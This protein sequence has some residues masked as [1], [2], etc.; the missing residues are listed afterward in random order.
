MHGGDDQVGEGFNFKYWSYILPLPASLPSCVQ[1]MEETFAAAAGGPEAEQEHAEP[2]VVNDRLS[3]AGGEVQQEREDRR[4]PDDEQGKNFVELGDHCHKVFW[5]VT[6]KMRYEW[7]IRAFMDFTVNSVARSI[8]LYTVPIVVCVE[9]PLDFVKDL[10]AVM[11]I[12][13]LDNMDGDP[14]DLEELSVKTKFMLYFESAERKSVH[15]LKKHFLCLPSG[16]E[17]AAGGVCKIPLTKNEKDYIEDDDTKDKFKRL[18]DFA[19]EH[20]KSFTKEES[21]PLTP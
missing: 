21:K 18:K 12:T 19:P 7:L 3:P 2:L 11:F 5:V 9:G 4:S 17:E 6:I 8:I 10:T 1:T 15:E 20:W 16:G 13:M 14:K